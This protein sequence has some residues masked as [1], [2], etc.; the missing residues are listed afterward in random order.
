MLVNFAVHRNAPL[1]KRCKPANRPVQNG[2]PGG[3]VGAVSGCRR[4]GR[5]CPDRSALGS[6]RSADAGRGAA[7]ACPA[8]GTDSRGREGPRRARCVK[9]VRDQAGDP[10]AHRLA[11]DD[12]RPLG[13]RRGDRSPILRDQCVC[14]WQRPAATLGAAP[15]HVAELEASHAHSSRSQCVAGSGHRRAVHRRAGSVGK[16]DGRP[17]LNGTVQEKHVVRHQYGETG[18]IAATAAL[19][20]SQ[21]FKNVRCRQGLVQRHPS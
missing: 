20:T 3:G 14:P 1:V 5:V 17:R 2:A 9:L 15:G 10:S 13:I 12:E 11:A 18:L 4:A 8:D 19:R 6:A 7:P 16:E 21:L